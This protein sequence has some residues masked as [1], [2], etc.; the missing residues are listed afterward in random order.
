MMV[1]RSIHPLET[2]I[3]TFHKHGVRGRTPMVN[4]RFLYD[5]R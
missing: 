1:L 2:N 4:T 5:T 3:R